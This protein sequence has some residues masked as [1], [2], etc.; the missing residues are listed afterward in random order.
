MSTVGT[1]TTR[2]V[3]KG[4]ASTMGPI[5]CGR[6]SG[7][8]GGGNLS[9]EFSYEITNRR[10]QAVLWTWSPPPGPRV[11]KAERRPDG[12]CVVTFESTLDR[13]LA[14]YAKIEVMGLSALA[15]AGGRESWKAV[16]EKPPTPAPGGKP[17][18]ITFQIRVDGIPK[19]ESPIILKLEV[20]AEWSGPTGSGNFVQSWQNPVEIPE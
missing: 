11:V 7:G 18:E 9:L 1:V 4:A 6:G 5:G 20:K 17:A 14:E 15:P 10:V 8:S 3:S 13:A 2:P 12:S 16:L 19:G